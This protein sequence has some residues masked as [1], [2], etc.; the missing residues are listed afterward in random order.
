MG[1]LTKERQIEITFITVF[2]VLIFAIFYTLIS[3]NGVVLGNDPAVHL[4]KAQIFLQT[5]KI[6]LS[7][8]GW[9]PP[10]YEIVL[11]MF[12]SFSGA[13]DI[14][15]LIF[16]VKA[17]AVIVDWLLFL[18]VYLIGSK[19]FNKK[20][21]AVAAV[22][23]L[24]CFPM[25]EV[26]AFGG[27]TTVLAIAFMLLMFLYLPLAVEKFG[28]LLVTFFVSFALVLS[29][30]LA[31][32][33]AVIILPPILLYM[34]I[35]SRGAYLKVV[36]ALILGGGIAFF[37]YYFQAM[38]PYLGL[39]IEYV[40]FAQKSYAYQIPAASFNSF[41]VNFGFIFFFALSGIFISYYLLKIQKKLIFYVILMLSFFVPLF[42]AESY[43]FGLYM[44]FQW[45]IYYLT[46]PMAIFAAVSLTFIEEKFAV[47]YAKNKKSLR[48]NWLKIATVSII[49]LMSLMLVFRSNVV[50]G[51]IMEASVYYSTTDIKA[52]DAGVWLKQNYPNDATVVV[53]E[54]PGFWFSAFS[55]KNVIAQTDPTVQRNEIAESVLSLSY[56]IQDPQNLL[57]AYEAKGDTSDENYVSI[58]QVWY[59]VSYSSTAG[60]FISFTQNGTNYKF[61]LSDLSREIYFDNQSYPKN[62]E[63][64]Y[65]NDYVTL[66]QTMLV[67]NDSYPINV[68]WA[69]SPLN[70]DISNAT[71]YISTFFDLQFNFDKAQIPQLMDWV[72]PW[73]V[74]SKTTHG[75]EWAVVSFSGSDLKDNY[76][77][78][79]DDKN[80]IA[81]AFK[82]ND[83][84]DWGNIG[85]LASRQ[86]DAVRFQYQFNEVNVNQTVTR[87]YQVLSFSKNSFPALQPNELQSLFDFK[88]G[89]FTVSTRDYKDY[90]AENNIEFIVYDKNQLDTKM[91]RCK[92]LE[93]I[94]SN[95][96]YDIFKILS[97]YNQTQV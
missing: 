60:D 29:H 81:L 16:L 93:L 83:L 12:I 50:Y 24:M 2:S 55:D 71:L 57:R 47:Y 91:V 54:I 59:R 58:D 52:Y 27:Y 41:M 22:L 56:E 49:V 15:Q 72:N 87:Q 5:G 9:T 10:L 6:P 75:T 40:F 53:T 4:E 73:D 11:A 85:A 66:T 43:I 37:L 23:L 32:F 80:Q 70:N 7:N 8:L 79:Y 61:A 44:P 95:D 76:I 69:V 51:K 36:I 46:A 62:I 67:Q 86:I 64:R 94:Y 26:N 17:L 14:G 3:M 1:K 48:K 34:L 45:F 90:I 13:T 74:P 20:V 19:F 96:R 39:V 35:K 97:S 18:S 92:F 77:G 88:P 63:F 38:V 33:L 21:G 25:Y 78:L 31:A 42:F 82:F 65:S 28:Y 84:P 30:Q 89:E 68:S